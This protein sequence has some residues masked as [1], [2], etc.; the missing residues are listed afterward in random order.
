[1]RACIAALASALLVAAPASA[2]HLEVAHHAGR[3]VLEALDGGEV[4]AARQALGPREADKLAD[5]FGD[6]WRD[7]AAAARRIANRDGALF[8]GCALCVRDQ[9]FART[10]AALCSA[11]NNPG[12]RTQPGRLSRS[13]H[14]SVALD[15]YPGRRA[16]RCAHRRRRKICRTSPS[17]GNRILTSTSSARM[18]RLAPLPVLGS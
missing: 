15:R 13:A 12:C 2:H 18:P 7:G 10:R 3:V 4:E 1:M 17:P 11:R 8:R 5:A 16:W 14:R 9:F 6:G